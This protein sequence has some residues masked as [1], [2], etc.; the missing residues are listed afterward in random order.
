VL[1]MRCCVI[2]IVSASFSLAALSVRA[3][4]S[5]YVLKWTD[6]RG[7]VGY[8][9]NSD[10][11]VD[12]AGRVYVAGSYGASGSYL[13]QYNADG[14]FG[15]ERSESDSFRFGRGVS[16]DGMGHVYL[17]GE[18]NS[19]PG[20]CCNQD[21]FLT[22]YTTAGDV[23]WSA[24]TGSEYDEEKVSVA[25][26]A[27]GNVFV[28]G[29]TWG[30]LQGPNAGIIDIFAAKYD[31]NGNLQWMRQYGSNEEDEAMAV[32]ADGLGN[33]YVAGYIGPAE[34]RTASG[35]FVTKFD[36]DGNKLWTRFPGLPDDP[37]IA[38]DVFVDDVGRVILAGGTYSDL[39]TPP[40]VSNIFRPFVAVF[41]MDGD[42]E[43]Q[44]TYDTD[45]S[46]SYARGVTADAS[47]HI[48]MVGSL[49]IGT[50]SPTAFIA[51]VAASGELIQMLE[52]DSGEGDTVEEVA[53]QG[54][55]IYAVGITRGSLFGPNQGENDGI[56]MRLESVP[57][58][59]TGFL[60]L[61]A[62]LWSLG[63]RLKARHQIL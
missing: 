46:F 17:A 30:N 48:H 35:A 23:E 63:C 18:Y 62:G 28:S 55:A 3:A 8:E 6:Q 54:A 32:A 37:G 25:A 59:A 60:L 57:E 1:S 53:A 10:V 7:T 11:A 4:D 9:F 5:P 2:W 26:D 52:F 50:D 12:E 15:W 39:E 51:K 40:T 43:W 33:A 34:G 44:K 49:E 47:G 58:P 20:D 19:R 38:M 45:P 27:L 16:A 41:D 61:V 22:K 21:V 13:L 29:S 56:V 31:S 24:A 42:L 36:S 14:T